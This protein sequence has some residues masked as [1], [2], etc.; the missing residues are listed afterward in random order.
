[1]QEVGGS[2]P[3]L[4]GLRLSQFQASGGIGTLQSMASSLQS[5]TQESFIRTKDNSSESNKR[6]R[7]QEQLVKPSPFCLADGPCLR[8]A[9][10][11]LASFG[12]RFLESCL[13]AGG[14]RPLKTRSRSSRIHEHAALTHALKAIGALTHVSLPNSATSIRA[15]PIWLLPIAGASRAPPRRG[16]GREMES[17][18]PDCFP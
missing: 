3:R 1:M 9:P 8:V 2:N 12:S 17:R 16:V 6:W 13:C 7:I 10:H 15:T 11:K 4:G 18:E 5:T 14:F